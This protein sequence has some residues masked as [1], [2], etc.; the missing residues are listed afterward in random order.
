MKLSRRRGA[1]SAHLLM[2]VKLRAPQHQNKSLVPE[3]KSTAG[4]M[5]CFFQDQSL[6]SY[7]CLCVLV[8][9]SLDSNVHVH[10]H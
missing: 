2:L 6:Y 8:F 5:L 7:G 1:F 9:M 3:R 10:M 4:L